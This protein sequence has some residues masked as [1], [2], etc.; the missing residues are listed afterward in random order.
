MGLTVVSVTTSVSGIRLGFSEPVDTTVLNL[1]KVPGYSGNPDLRVLDSAMNAV[2]GSL[3]VSVDARFVDFVATAGISNDNYTLIVASGTHGFRVNSGAL[4]DGNADGISGDNYVT[5]IELPASPSVVVSTDSFARAPGETASS[6]LNSDANLDIKVE[7]TEPIEAIDFTLSFNPELLDI[8]NLSVGDGVP[9]GASIT[10][11]TV[12]PGNIY[13]RFL[14]PSPVQ[15][16]ISNFVSVDA[17]VASGANYGEAGLIEIQDVV[18]NNG[19]VSAT[20]RSSVQLVAKLGDAN[21]DGKH[22]TID[23]ILAARLAVRP[24][25]GLAS[26]PLLDPS[27][28]LDVSGSGDRTMFDSALI[29]KCE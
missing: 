28:V 10:Y 13:I 23:S 9:R 26:Y 2:P 5:P 1:L 29:A 20:G 18:V 14:S 24:N 21:A 19:A 22:S 16:G 4:L 25:R 7:T 27:L 3:F 11:S 12:E 6:S 15:V 8:E 17:S